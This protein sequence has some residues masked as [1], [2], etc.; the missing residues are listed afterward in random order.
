[1]LFHCAVAIRELLAVA[2]RIRAAVPKVTR[3]WACS[4]MAA[5]R[6]AQ[7]LQALNAERELQRVVDAGR[8][9]LDSPF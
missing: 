7:L 9:T 6:D 4:A 3:V 1:M 2:A 8:A 5:S